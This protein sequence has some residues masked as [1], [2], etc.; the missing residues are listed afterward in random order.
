MLWATE[1]TPDE[2]PRDAKE[3]L[4][5]LRQIERELGISP[6]TAPPIAPPATT[7]AFSDSVDI[8]K[9]LPG[10]LASTAPTVTVER[11][12]DNASRLRRRTRRRR[13]RGGWLLA[14]VL[15][16]AVLA[17]GAGW[18]FGSGPGALIAVPPLAGL[19]S[20][21]EAEDV[22][23]EVGLRAAEEGEHTREVA[24]G[25]V[26]RSDPEEG[27]RLEANELVTVFVSLG[28]QL[29][30]VEALRGRDAAE[31]RAQL[32]SLG[33]TVD[34]DESIFS[35]QTAR[36][37]V[38]R[39]TIHPA[40]GADSYRCNDGCE[41]YDGDSATL[42]VSVGPVPDVSGL[43]V[44]DATRVL[45]QSGL[46][47]DDELTRRHH[48][49]VAADRVIGIADRSSEGNWRPGETVRLIVSDGPAP[50]EIPD[51]S[52]GSVRNAMDTLTGLGFRPTTLVPEFFWD[53]FSVQRTDPPPASGVCAAP[54]CGSS[55]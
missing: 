14:L 1:K 46:D 19:S 29:H 39:A 24:E 52:D 13:S 27:E 44:P 12:E 31:V 38:A 47:V 50:I 32:E 23:A 9:V 20:F 42:L 43:S 4:D 10:T 25:V 36:D 55:P 7:K 35:D 26:I 51:L 15:L 2:R 40:S 28:P 17:G 22:L 54:R 45:E 21:E 30:R 34:D 8:T 37:A 53:I 18:W 33:V 49:S 6:L 48:E 41:L 16:L 3:M 11:Q 5:R